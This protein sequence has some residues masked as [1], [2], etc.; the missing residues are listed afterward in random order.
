MLGFEY[1]CKREALGAV[2]ATGVAFGAGVALAE[3]PQHGCYM[4]D[5]SEAHL[6]KHPTQIVDWMTLWVYEDEDRD[7]MANMTVGFARQGNVRGTV[8][9]GETVS[10][11]LVCFDMD[12]VPGCGVECDGGY[13]TVERDQADGMTIETRYLLVGDTDECGGAVDLAEVEGQAVRYRLNRVD[14][15]QCVSG[16]DSAGLVG[17][18]MSDEGE[19]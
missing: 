8:F 7:T 3:G 19:S 1:F 16:E 17:D 18:E 12:G 14:S 13:F 10:Q 4:R 15:G 2:V 9:A 6:A 5:Y 11:A